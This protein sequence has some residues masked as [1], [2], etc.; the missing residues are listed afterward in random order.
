MLTLTIAFGKTGGNKTGIQEG[1]RASDILSELLL[2]C[3]N[4]DDL[5]L[6]ARKYMD[7]EQQPLYFC[8]V[9]GCARRYSRADGVR[10]H[11]ERSHESNHQC[12][13]EVAH[14]MVIEGEHNSSS[15]CNI[16]NLTIAFGNNSKHNS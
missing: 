6:L 11:I 4:H 12:L 2:A 3:M 16:T 7:K 14:K 13:A 10:R 15:Q 8:P 9:E 1:S 5:Q